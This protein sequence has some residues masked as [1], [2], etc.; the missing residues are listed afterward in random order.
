MKL[1]EQIREAWRYAQQFNVMEG[2]WS[3]ME[4]WAIRAAAMEKHS[5]ERERSF[6]DLLAGKEQNDATE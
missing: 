6:D 2:M 5:E 3:S 4:V 1:S